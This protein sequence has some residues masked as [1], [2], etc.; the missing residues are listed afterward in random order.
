MLKSLQTLF[1][2]KSSDLEERQFSSLHKIVLNITSRSLE[3]ELSICGS[4]IDR[5]DSRGNTALSWA[6]RKGDSTAIYLLLKDNADPNLV[7]QFGL[8]PLL[9]AARESDPTSVKLLLKAGADP[10]QVDDEYYNALHYAAEFQNGR[11]TIECLVEAGVDVNKQNM[12]GSTPLTQAALMN[13]TIS[14]EV[15][16]DRGA[17]PNVVDFERDSPLTESLYP[18]ADDMTELLLHRGAAYISS[19]VYGDTILHLA[20]LC[21]GLRT[22]SILQAAELKGIDPDATN[23]KGKTAIHIARER[24]GKPYGFLPQFQDLLAGIRARNASQEVSSQKDTNPVSPDSTSSNPA[25]LSFLAKWVRQLKPR[26]IN[27]RSGFRWPPRLSTAMLHPRT[28]WASRFFWAHWVLG[29]CCAGLLYLF[30]KFGVMRRLRMM[31][32]MLEPGGF[33]EV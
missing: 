3:E 15:L 30:L 11:E 8:S 5:F 18:G 12:W 19:T 26:S 17:D 4:N 6:A 2:G 29:L 28:Q 14:A 16:L 21:G 32:D 27:R 20:A 13:N 10:N 25:Y 9:Y 23:K 1:P 22:L 33:E 7:N 31:W 24:E